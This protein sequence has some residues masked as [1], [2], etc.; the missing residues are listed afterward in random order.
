MPLRLSASAD[1]GVGLAD[2]GGHIPVITADATVEHK[3]LFYLQAAYRRFFIVLRAGE[4]T[5]MPYWLPSGQ[6]GP[7]R[8]DG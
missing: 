6:R 7:V 2:I 1:G 8:K 3:G 4:V 5:P